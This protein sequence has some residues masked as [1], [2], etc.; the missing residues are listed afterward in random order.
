MTG[1][2]LKGLSPSSSH[3]GGIQS[4]PPAR[5]WSALDWLLVTQLSP[6]L[7]EWSGIVSLTRI[8]LPRTT[9]RGHH[10]I[11]THTYTHMHTKRNRQWRAVWEQQS[12]FSQASDWKLQGNHIV[13]SVSEEY[14]VFCLSG[15]CLTTA[16]FCAFV[17]FV[18]VHFWSK[19][20]CET[21]FSSGRTEQIKK[22]WS[23]FNVYV[24][25]TTND[26]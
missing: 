1:Q 19:V 26:Y 11:L 15:S 10:S 8:L 18:H 2:L 22:C 13:S 12:H 5:V 14:R 7:F 3:R 17:H 9:K 4:P 23:C 16:S 6:S 24:I 25:I 20:V 21:L